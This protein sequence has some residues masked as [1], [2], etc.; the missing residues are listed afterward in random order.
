MY[1]DFENEM[2]MV[3][4]MFKYSYVTLL[5]FLTSMLVIHLK[6]VKKINDTARYDTTRH[7]KTQLL[8]DIK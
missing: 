4:G 5:T 2:L 7:D 1:I 8:L 3:Y 6:C